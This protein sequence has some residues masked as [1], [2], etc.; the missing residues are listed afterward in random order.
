MSG[1]PA[2]KA[3]AG[4]LAKAAIVAALVIG[5]GAVVYLKAGPGAGGIAREGADATAEPAAPVGLPRLVDL[6]SDESGPSKAMAPILDELAREYAG[7]LDVVIIDVKKHPENAAQYGAKDIPT[8][9]FFDGAGIERFRHDGFFSKE[10]ILGKWKD[11]GVTLTV[12][13]QGVSADPPPPPT[14]PTPPD[15]AAAPAAPPVAGQ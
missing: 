12:N 8:Q 15:P 14:P 9:V 2:E 10:D 5:I 7:Q 13:A 4:L 3:Q 11:L 6:G 1:E